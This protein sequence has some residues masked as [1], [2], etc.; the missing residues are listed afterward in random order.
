[1]TKSESRQNNAYLKIKAR[2]FERA[3]IVVILHKKVVLCRIFLYV[4]Q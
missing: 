3:F 4:K 2:S 1:M